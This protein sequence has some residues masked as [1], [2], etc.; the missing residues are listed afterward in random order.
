MATTF[1]TLLGFGLIIYTVTEIA[2]IPE[3]LSKHRTDAIVM[4]FCGFCLVSGSIIIG[5][6]P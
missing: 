6:F 2:T 4:V 3:W 5:G 1:F